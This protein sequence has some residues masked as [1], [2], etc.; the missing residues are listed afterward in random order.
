MCPSYVGVTADFSCNT[1]AYRYREV[2]VALISEFGKDFFD[3]QVCTD[4]PGT[5]CA[6]S[7][8]SLL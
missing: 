6:L 5:C 4:G 7:T 3:A 2:K 8:T 1:L